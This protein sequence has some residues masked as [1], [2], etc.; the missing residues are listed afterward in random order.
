MALFSTAGMVPLYSGVTARTRSAPPTRSRSR[1]AAAGTC[2]AVDLLVVERDLVEA[3]GDLELDARGGVGAEQVDDA[4][5]EGVGT[6]AAE[7]DDDAGGV[8]TGG[9]SRVISERSTSSTGPWSASIPARRRA[10]P[11]PT[12]I[13]VMSTSRV[14]GAHEP[15]G[16]PAPA[17]RRAR[18]RA[19]RRRAQP[20]R[21]ARGR[22]TTD[23]A[24]RHRR[25]DDGR[26]RRGRGRRQGHGVPPVRVP[27]GTDGRAA[28]PLRDRVAGRRAE[29]PGPAGAR[30]R[31]P[32]T[33]CW[34][35]VARAWR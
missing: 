9:S 15:Q 8:D 26:G 20:G 21:A 3:L 23:R 6:Q 30:G 5:V 27:R 12:V 31:R 1:R 22:R 7:Q 25:R 13:R 28:Q 2:V 32:G 24:L 18:A 29:R 16:R 33:G 17:A 34:P 14:D 11:V 35:S 19:P 4:T 10:A